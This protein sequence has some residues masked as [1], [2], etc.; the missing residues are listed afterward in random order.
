VIRA[1]RQRCAGE[2]SAWNTSATADEIGELEAQ[3]AA[4]LGREGF[5]RSEHV[6]SRSADEFAAEVL[7]AFHDP[8]EGLYGYCYRDDPSGSHPVKWV[9]M[10]VSRAG[11]GVRPVRFDD[12]L[13]MGIYDRAALAPGDRID[14]PAVIDEFGSTMPVDPGFTVTVD[15]FGNLN[16]TRGPVSA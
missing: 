9:N 1:Q 8:H 6:Y 11:T 14:G 5:D 13:D 15:A 16:L 2:T 10:R 12:W 3:A 4:A 7:A